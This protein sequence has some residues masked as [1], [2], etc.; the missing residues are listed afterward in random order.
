VGV[1]GG[2][3]NRTTIFADVTKAPYSA[4]NTGAK[5]ASTAINNAIAACPANQVVYLPAGNYKISNPI[6][7]N[8]KQGVTLRGA[9]NST[10]LVADPNLTAYQ[11]IHVGAGTS[12]TTGPFVNQVN[13]TGGYAQ[14][15]NV[16]TLSSV[17]NY[18]VG[19]LIYLT[20]TDDPS[21]VW[22]DSSSTQN[23]KQVTSI[24]AISG[25]NVTIFPPLFWTQWSASRK[26][27]CQNFGAP[28]YQCSLCGLESFKVDMSTTVN[29]TVGI[30]IEQAYACWLT[31]VY[32]NKVHNYGTVVSSSCCLQ[33]N[34]DTWWDA[35]LHVQNCG[36]LVFYTAVSSSLIEDNIIYRN[37]P[38]MEID[39][40]SSGNAFLYNAMI[41]N[42][43]DFVGQSGHVQEYAFDGNHAPH[44]CMNLW[45][46]NYGA[47][48]I[49]DGY[50]G[51]GSHFTIFRN[52]FHGTNEEGLI[53]NSRCLDLCKWSLYNNVVGN[54]LG[55]TG[56][57]NVYDERTQNYSGLTDRVILRFGYP[58]MGNG[59]YTSIRPYSTDKVN[60]L[61]LAVRPSSEINNGQVGTT[62]L[63]GNWDSIHNMIVWDPSITNHALPNS[64]YYSSKPAYFN[65]LAWPPF[66]PANPGS[67]SVNSIPAGYRYTYGT[68]P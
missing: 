14:G 50:H 8:F 28:S 9:G 52:R 48:F 61:D 56:L 32:I 49:N 6:S 59:D 21:L 31:N 47:D 45:E 39:G 35:Q 41:D 10:V 54:V 68:N 5:D 4:D 58:N 13:W 44:N 2:I 29:T 62:L 51:S 15:S 63:T 18:K 22:T 16:I 26:P 37:A 60:A 36:G 55:T 34:R 64:Y 25:N 33:F 43:S 3:P 1:P 67:A 23:I 11:L 30:F 17:A 38:G 19:Q 65:S 40:G 46:G 42:Y 57:S 7:F 24:T 66:D 20:Q 27:V 12:T 53:E